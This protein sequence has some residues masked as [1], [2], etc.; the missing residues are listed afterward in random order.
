MRRGMGMGAGG[1]RCG[2]GYG[3]GG[4]RGYRNRF[5]AGTTATADE[6]AALQQQID[7]LQRRLDAARATTHV[8]ESQ[9]Q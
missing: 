8:T 1:G 3:R 5:V 7:A 4:G 9:G 6:P 2:G